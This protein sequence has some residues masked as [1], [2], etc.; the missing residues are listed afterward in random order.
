MTC[1]FSGLKTVRSDEMITK[2]EVRSVMQDTEAVSPT[3][4]DWL[5]P[6]V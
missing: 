5:K 3:I 2:P 4:F 1:V 6:S